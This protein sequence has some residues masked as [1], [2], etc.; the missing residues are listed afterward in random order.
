[1]QDHVW[2]TIRARAVEAFGEAPGPALDERLLE[3]FMKQPPLGGGDL[4]VDTI[5]KVIES[6]RAG[7]VQR[8][9][10]IVEMNLTAAI[11]AIAAGKTSTVGRAERLQ[12]NARLWTR[13]AGWQLPEHE[14]LDELFGDRGMLRD[15]S[16]DKQLRE[17]MLTL[18][19]E[20]ANANAVVAP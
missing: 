6:Y 12:S 11:E 20:L 16:D 2:S 4:V 14:F 5:S 3:T 1:M 9:W 15:I 17:A 8:P 13:N 18:R 19:L 7:K 10:A